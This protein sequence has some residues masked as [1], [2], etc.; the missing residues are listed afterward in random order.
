[1]MKPASWLALAALA[2]LAPV[3]LGAV[4]LDFYAGPSVNEFSMVH[5]SR[6]TGGFGLGAQAWI[7]P[8]LGVDAGIADLGRVDG[9]FPIEA[10][11]PPGQPIPQYVLQT[12]GTNSLNVSS[13]AAY[14]LAEV[15]THLGDRVGAWL[16]L[17]PDLAGTRAT[18]NLFIGLPVGHPTYSGTRNA[19]GFMARAGADLE[20]AKGLSLDLD[21]HYSRAPAFD[22]FTFYPQFE[23]ADIGSRQLQVLGVGIELVWSLNAPRAAR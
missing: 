8:F 5:D 20:I 3:R 11:Y 18:S 9:G 7:L 17:G 4:D 6:T 21:L 15:R 16:G 22:Q 14:A 12:S 13:S 2:A 10:T 19:V 23:N 1:M